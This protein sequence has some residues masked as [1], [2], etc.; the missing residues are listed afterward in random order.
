MIGQVLEYA[1]YLWKMTFEDFD[2]LFVSREGTPVLDLLEATVADIDREEVRHAIA[3]NLSSG[4]FRLFI[5]VDRM[6]EEL[7]KI[8]SYVSSRGSGLRLEVL[9][10]DLHQSG[11]MEILVPRRYGHNGTPP[12]TRPVKRI[13][14]IMVAIAG[15]RR[16]RM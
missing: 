8:I 5:A 14:E 12:P 4:S 7:E 11:Q 1:A 15:S 13:D 10:F 6:N 9:E 3:N 2:K 16:M